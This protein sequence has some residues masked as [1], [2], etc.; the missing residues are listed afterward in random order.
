MKLSAILG[1]GALCVVILVV[2]TTQRY[3]LPH[4]RASKVASATPIA[5]PPGI[6]MQLV[7]R[8]KHAG[9][10]SGPQIVFA[11][12]KGMTLYTYASDTVGHGGIGAASACV[13]ECAKIW[14]AALAAQDAGAATDWSVLRRADGS[15]QW[16]YRGAPLYRFA[17]DEAPGEIKGQGSE[18]GAWRAAAFVPE[19]GLVLPDSKIGRAHV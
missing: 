18:S 8:G 6:T 5:T 12:D 2:A 11:D 9:R 14:Q 13:G 7:S 15:R 10:S 16:C 4:A 19:A 3:W 17:G 1:L